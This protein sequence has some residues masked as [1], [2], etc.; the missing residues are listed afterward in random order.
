MTADVSALVDKRAC[1]CH[2]FILLTLGR[3]IQ[4]TSVLVYNLVF[5]FGSIK[6]VA[7]R[8]LT[9]LGPKATII[10]SSTVCFGRTVP[11]TTYMADPQ[12]PD[13]STG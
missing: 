13:E 11:L 12:Q 4:H 1:A 8:Q 5:L 2:G 9:V 6:S 10:L 3:D 7:T